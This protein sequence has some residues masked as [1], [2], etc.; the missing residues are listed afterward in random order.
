MSCAAQDEIQIEV[1]AGLGHITLSRPQALNALSL[2][3]VRSLLQTLQ[4]WAQDPAIQAVALRGQGREGPFGV[5]CAGGDI[6][7]LHQAALSG[8]PRIEDFF[9]EEY[10]LVYL[11]HHYPKPY[12]AFMDGVVMGGGMGISQGAG[13]RLVTERSKLAMPETAIGLFPD[14]GGGYFLSRTPGH[15]GEYLGLTG[16]VISG[17]QAVEL[18]LADLLLP[19]AELPA[20]WAELAEWRWRDVQELRQFLAQRYGGAPGQCPS[21]QALPLAQINDCFAAGDVAAVLARLEADSSPWAQRVAGLLRSR[22]PLMLHVVLELIRRCRQL[23]LAEDLRLERSLVRRCFSLRL[24][25]RSETVEGIRAL[26]IDKDHAPRW[27]PARIEEVSAAEV[28]AYFEPAWPAHSHPL[29]SL[30]LRA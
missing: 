3:M 17:A 27:Q 5:L 6:R 19:S 7:F 12:V 28:A 23:D 29:R 21:A 14:V 26:V 10:A 2:G 16:E 25:A 8:D 15:V 4:D 24:G 11:I 18:G 22:S 20:I 13:L 1:Q 30:G 9:S